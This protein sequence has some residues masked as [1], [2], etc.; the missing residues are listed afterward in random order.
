[1]NKVG[2]HAKG[3]PAA[4]AS[5]ITRAVGFLI[6]ARGVPVASTVDCPDVGIENKM[7]AIANKN[8]GLGVIIT[9]VLHWQWGTG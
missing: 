5:G 8:R 7:A 2:S 3:Q 1:M 4:Y 9:F 6:L